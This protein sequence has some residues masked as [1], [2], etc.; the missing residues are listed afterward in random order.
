MRKSLII[1]EIRMFAGNFA[2]QDGL[3][4]RSILPIAQNQGVIF[5]SRYYFMEEME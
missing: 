1:G 3:L 2:L 5:A 4:S